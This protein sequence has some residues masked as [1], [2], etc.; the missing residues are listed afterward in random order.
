MRSFNTIR[1]RATK[2]KGGE[3]EL[4]SLLPKIERPRALAKLPDDR[5]LSAMAKRIFSAGFVWSVVENKWPGFEAAFLDF[6]PKRLVFQPDE[7]WVALADDA[8]I[9]RNP[10]KIRAVRH[11]A[12]FVCD[13]AEQHGSFGKF[14][15]GWPAD[16]QVGLLD[17]LGQ[18]GAR[19]GGRTGQFFLRF[20]GKDCFVTSADVVA[21]LRDAGLEI[22]ENPTSRKDLT[23]IQKQFNAWA[24]ET[25]LPYTH[26]SRI[27]AMSIGENYDAAM[28]RHRAGADE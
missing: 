21:C 11:N 10:Q 9:V 22:A 17:V 5:V 20:I 16:D 1:A 24:A 8:R 27:C 28:L 3:D 2:R 14:L 7:F 4:L 19:L 12:Q 6:A 25:G 13:V 23:K 26:L 15:A 18:R